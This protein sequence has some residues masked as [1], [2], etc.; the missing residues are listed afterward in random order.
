MRL[1]GDPRLFAT[2][3]APNVWRSYVERGRPL[4]CPVLWC[5]ACG[6][7]G[8]ASDICDRDSVLG[9]TVQK[10]VRYPVGEPVQLC[11]RCFLEVKEISRMQA[12]LN[13]IAGIAKTLKR[14]ARAWAQK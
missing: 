11:R 6:K 13:E 3:V 4:F 14:E 2:Q 8:S 1:P 5:E 10:L 7:L 9:W 12:E